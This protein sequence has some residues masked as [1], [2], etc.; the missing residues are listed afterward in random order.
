L[1]GD[2]LL[3]GHD[4]DRLPLIVEFLEQPDDLDGR[5]G[6]QVARGLVGEQ[7]RGL[8]D[9][10]PRDRDPL[11]LPARQ[12]VGAVPHPVAQPDASQARSSPRPALNRLRRL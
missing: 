10:R 5:L 1:P 2:I 6:V 8:V 7:D 9:E 3:V 12:L 4:H 11:P